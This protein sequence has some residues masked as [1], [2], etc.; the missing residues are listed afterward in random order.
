VVF[1]PEKEIPASNSERLIEV[2]QFLS[3]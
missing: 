1:D 3:S 2:C